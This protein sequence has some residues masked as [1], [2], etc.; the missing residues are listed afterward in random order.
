MIKTEQLVGAWKADSN[1]FD[2]QEE[3]YLQFDVDGKLTQTSKKGDK[4]DVIF[5]TFKVENEDLVTDQPS[6]P[7]IERTKIKMENEKL[8]LDYNGTEAVFSR[9]FGLPKQR[10]RLQYKYCWNIVSDTQH[11]TTAFAVAK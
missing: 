4:Q 10:A 8:I 1:P 6:A 11:K 5:L 7:R 9:Y 3:L 2:P